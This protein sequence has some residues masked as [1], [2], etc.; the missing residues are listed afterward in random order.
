MLVLGVLSVKGI[1]GVDRKY[2]HD[3]INE[4]LHLRWLT[5]EKFKNYE[6]VKGL[7]GGCIP[8]RKKLKTQINGK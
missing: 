2:D 4:A 7:K 6:T 3:T 5:N 1:T 8:S